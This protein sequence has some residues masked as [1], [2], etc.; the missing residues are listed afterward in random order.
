MRF[1][2]QGNERWNCSKTAN[3]L[4]DLSSLFDCPHLYEGGNRA[5]LT[6]FFWASANRWLLGLICNVSS[7]LGLKPASLSWRFWTFLSLSL[8]SPHPASSSPLLSLSSLGNLTNTD[9]G[10]PLTFCKSLLN[11]YSVFKFL[12]DYWWLSF[13]LVDGDLLFIAHFHVFSLCQRS[14]R[15]R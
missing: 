8:S 15:T 9:F 13:I 7:S 12:C 5:F 10:R 1:G 14:R 3:W 4:C 2:N 11:P 6:G